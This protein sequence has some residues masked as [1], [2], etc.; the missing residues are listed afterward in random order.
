VI[1]SA[2]YWLNRALKNKHQAGPAEEF[3]KIQDVAP[4][5]FVSHRSGVKKVDNPGASTPQML[6]ES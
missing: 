1:I 6:G 4:S 3:P 5:V 2:S